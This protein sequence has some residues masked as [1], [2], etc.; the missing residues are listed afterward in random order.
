MLKTK[1]PNPIL[2]PIQGALPLLQDELSQ[3]EELI[4]SQFASPVSLVGQIADYLKDDPGKRL[5]SI[6]SLLSARMC[7]PEPNPKAITVGACVELIHAATLF[8]DDVIDG[9]MVRRGKPCVHQ[10]W[11]NQISILMGDFLF[12]RAFEMIM[13]IKSWPLLNM[14]SKTIASMAEGEILQM[15]RQGDLETREETYFQIIQAKTAALF[16]SACKGGA[17]VSPAS[18]REILMLE[19]YGYNLGILFQLTDDLLDYTLNL[20]EDF[21]TGKITLPLMLIYEKLS[22]QE[23]KC[24]RELKDFNQI[25][26]FFKYYNIEKIILE[27]AEIYAQNSLKS[28]EGFGSSIEKN[29]LS[30]LV[31]F[32]LHRKA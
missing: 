7:H 9:S 18:S 14:L 31:S 4:W 13:E 1:A 2:S 12:S 15:T 27:R 10:V 25:I 23:K 28:L 22:D 11:G 20:G 29:L 6:L 21:K 30:E 32:C 8:H 19:S 16:S 24:I 26:S 3:I 5:R 17:L